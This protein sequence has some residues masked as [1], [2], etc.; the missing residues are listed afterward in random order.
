MRTVIVGAGLVG[1][2]TAASLR[3]IG[4]DVTV[5]EHAPEVRAV[6]AGIGLWPNALREFDKLG[7]GDAVRRMGDTVDAW[8][9]DAAGK[10]ER[11]DGYDPS[12]YRFLMVPR[13]G[14]NTLLAETVGL[15]R[16]RLGTHVTGFTE[17][18]T[19]VEVHVSDGPS[20]RADLLIGADGV[21]SDVRAAL[22]PGSSAVEHEGNR[23]W[24][25][26]VPSGDERP[27]TTS[28]R[29]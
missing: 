2:T 17:H 10:P 22:V 6:G 1:L 27:G 20:S 29:R 4:H 18:D 11:A 24:R 12:R 3:L 28:W 26:M 5:L 13:P 25:A 16:I 9:F 8:F 21:Y 15:E 14:L 19:H 7:I 23:V